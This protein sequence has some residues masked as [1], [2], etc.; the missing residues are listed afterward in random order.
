MD[1][2]PSPIVFENNDGK[3]VRSSRIVEAH[4]VGAA[5]ALPD[6]HR[7]IGR[8]QEGELHFELITK[9][10]RGDVEVKIDSVRSASSRYAVCLAP[11]GYARVQDGR[12]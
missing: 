4:D 6:I 5:R 8:V 7:P 1:S 3:P 11:S 10:A 12:R 9:H 2:P